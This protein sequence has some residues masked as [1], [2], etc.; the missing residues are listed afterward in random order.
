MRINVVVITYNGSQFIERC[1]ESLLK[2]FLEEEITIV[3]N[4]SSDNTIELVET[5]FPN[6]KIII[7][8]ENLGFGSAC[9][10]GCHSVDSNLVMFV[11]QDSKFVSIDKTSIYSLFDNERIGL[12][13][14][15]VLGI[16]GS[17]I[18]SVGRGLSPSTI[19]AHW[20][21][22]PLSF[23]GIT[24]FQMVEAGKPP[25]SD[26]QWVNGHVM[27]V[28]KSSF[29]EVGG[30][31]ES[32]FMY[33]EEV[34]LCYRMRDAGYKVVFSSDVSSID[35]NPSRNGLGGLSELAVH[36]SLLGHG[37]FT[38][39]RHG[40][41]VGITVRTLSSLASIVWGICS[42]PLFILNRAHGRS[43]IS[44]IIGGFRGLL[45]LSRNE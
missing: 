30:F 38:T 36:H 13:G 37:I 8:Q 32:F 33:V 2:Y 25:L 9:N 11:N 43:S 34:D 22:L 44:L 41:F 5:L 1:V 19:F 12:M 24:Y 18:D 26:V 40:F 6:V 29:N 35:Y 31:D 4:N 28:D 21:F 20:L 7:N 23:L 39:K 42:T 15:R 45:G 3:D 17:D 14:G 10:I 27:I 16:S